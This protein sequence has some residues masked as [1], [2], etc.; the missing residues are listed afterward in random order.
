MLTITKIA[1]AIRFVQQAISGFVSHTGALCVFKGMCDERT[2]FSNYQVLL[3]RFQ[4]DYC[5]DIQ[6]GSAKL[7]VGVGLKIDI[8]ELSQRNHNLPLAEIHSFLQ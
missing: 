5:L 3:K 4:R 8:K 6:T 2:K 1:V 7:K